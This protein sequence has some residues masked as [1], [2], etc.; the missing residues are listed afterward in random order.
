MKRN[1]LNSIILTA[2]L[3]VLST[4]CNDKLE[5]A[6]PY[7][8]ISVVYGLLDMNDTAHYIRVQKA[9]MDQNKS[10]LDMAKEADSNYYR[11]IDVVIK[12]IDGNNRLLNT[13]NLSRVDLDQEG[14]PKASGTFFNSP[15]IAYKFKHALSPSNKYRLLITN[16][17]TGRIDSSET[18]VLNNG[19]GNVSIFGL[20][21][22]LSP[23]FR[24]AFNRV[25]DDNGK[26]VNT[27]YE[28]I[29]PPT[30]AAAEL[31][32]KLNW[33]DSNTVTGEVTPHQSIFN[34]FI[35][36]NK[37]VPNPVASTTANLSV[38][39]IRFYEFVALEMGKP[40]NANIVRKFK[41]SDMILYAAGTEM[42]RYKELNATNGG[43]TADEVRP[44]YT[45]MKGGNSM[46]LFATR[47]HTIKADAPVDTLTINALRNHELTKDLNIQL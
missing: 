19:G 27:T 44:L 11:N 47:V 34:H 3:G 45:N 23:R 40:A 12:E 1:I 26:D 5:I 30:A 24:I 6:A 9:F 4:S 41:N 39:N 32:I 10:G 22:W 17:E 46:G 18:N 15:N 2:A 29:I 37:V 13:I 33:I 7:E 42:I 14:Y 38:P 28:A 36:T 16:K 43:L 35:P 31:L 20:R 25:K 21:D 8:N